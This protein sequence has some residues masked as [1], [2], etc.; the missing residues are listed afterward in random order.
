MNFNNYTIKS[1]EAVQQA[2]QLT[3]EL[4]H[5]HIDP[6]HLFKAMLEVDEHAVLH[7]FSL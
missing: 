6:E 5:Q 2:H 1:Q 3:Q 7:G 4:E